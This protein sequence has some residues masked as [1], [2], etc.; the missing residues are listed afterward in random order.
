MKKITK[1]IAPF[2]II[3]LLAPAVIGQE[4]IKTK[5]TLTPDSW[6]FIENWFGI[7]TPVIGQKFKLRIE[8]KYN[9]EPVE[10][11]KVTKA[12]GFIVNG[13]PEIE[14]DDYRAKTYIY[15]MQAPETEGLYKVTFESR[16]GQEELITYDTEIKVVEDDPKQNWVRGAIWLGFALGL[17]GGA[18]II[19]NAGK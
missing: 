3:C 6:L 10:Y 11:V 8:A 15:K 7:E 19:S 12:E 18:L 5:I 17:I 16:V 1:L 13:K 2:I 14:A 9:D 4:R